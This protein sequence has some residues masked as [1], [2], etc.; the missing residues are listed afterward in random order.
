MSNIFKIYYNSNIDNK[1]IYIFCKRFLEINS[2]T[3]EELK[4]K[5]LESNKNI[6]FEEIF[7]NYDYKLLE[8]ESKVIFI[9]ENIYFVKHH[10]KANQANHPLCYCL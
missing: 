4:N 10:I 3:L 7:D 1:I 5:F 9:N 2:L 6:I 8:N